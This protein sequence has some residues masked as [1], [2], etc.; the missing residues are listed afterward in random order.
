MVLLKDN[1]IG[2]YITDDLA[3]KIGCE[4]VG[5]EAVILPLSPP[6]PPFMGS[7]SEVPPGGK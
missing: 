6:T 5:I 7:S 3:A 1:G 4:A 2:I